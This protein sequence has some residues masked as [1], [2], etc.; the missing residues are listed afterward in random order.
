MKGTHLYWQNTFFL[1]DTL[2]NTFIIK[3][4][5]LGRCYGLATLFPSIKLNCV[6]SGFS[7]YSGA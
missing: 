3:R 5:L 7:I 6:H 2:L 4:R 1:G